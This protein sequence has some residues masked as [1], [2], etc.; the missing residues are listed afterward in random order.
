MTHR[1]HSGLILCKKILAHYSRRHTAHINAECGQYT[2]ILELTV[3]K[4]VIIIFN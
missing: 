2:E 1:E 4:I 3:S